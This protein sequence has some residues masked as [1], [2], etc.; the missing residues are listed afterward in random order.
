MKL[1]L[2]FC[3]L[4]VNSC[5][6]AYGKCQSSSVWRWECQDKSSITN[7]TRLPRCVKVHVDSAS[8]EATSLN[9][10]KLTCGNSSMLFPK[11][12]GTTLIGKDTVSFFP[13][14]ALKL[15]SYTCQGKPCS[16]QVKWLITNAF[17]ELQN[18][19]DLTLK[20]QENKNHQGSHQCY[21]ETTDR[22]I[23]VDIQMT[24]EEEKLTLDTDEGY[25]LTMTSTSDDVIQ[26]NIKATNFFGA[27]HA[28][29]TLSQ[30]S[31]Y[32]DE[33]NGLQIISSA[34]I[35]DKPSYPYRGLLLD[36]SRNYFSVANI[37]RLIKALSFNK[38]NTL[39]WH[40]TDTHSFPIEIKSVPEL[41]QYGAYDHNKVY[42]Q[43]DVREIME[44]ASYHGVRVLPEFDEPAHCGEG[45]QYGEKAG[46]GKLAVCVNREPWQQYC[47]E[48]PCGQLNPTNDNVYDVLGKIYKEYFDMFDPDLFHAGGDEIN[49]N[50]WNSTQEIADWLVQNYGGRSEEDIM[51]MW[52]MF[53]EKSS[54]KIYEANNGKEIPLILWT[55]GMTNNK[56]YLTKYM[57]PKR[58]IIQLW[59]GSTDSHIANIVN[60]GFKTIFST[61]DTLY[62]DCGY[63]NWLVKG[64]NWCSPYKDWKLLYEND[65][66]KILQTFNITV[67][68]AIRKSLLGQEAAM[69]SEQVDEHASEGKIWPRTAA[70]AERLWTN[71]DH[72][73]RDAEYRL[74]FHRERLVNRGVQADALQPLWCEQ[75]GGHCYY[76]S[77]I[78]G[79]H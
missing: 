62:L 78:K 21:R 49:F 69:W 68:D 52:G 77:S 74:I 1:I 47:V 10:C 75:N 30:L 36:T 20:E 34:D 73:W 22:Q 29:E 67:T 16:G 23:N 4:L 3:V 19:L 53:L 57:D 17:I 25:R 11:P 66:V 14:T 9:K 71:P 26:V 72:G 60:S 42:S 70:L 5:Q 46:L 41:Q 59:T 8:N 58:H 37:K 18:T 43:S 79:H 27:R 12:S 55:S 56:N 44:Y 6:L 7:E 15:K 35:T 13:S 64:N 32:D 48:P 76:D 63:G 31:A 33:S 51:K 45:W 24:T 50:C 38:M 2:I 39:H 40:I 65:P 54:N 28:L 61:Y